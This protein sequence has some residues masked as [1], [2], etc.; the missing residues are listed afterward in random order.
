TLDPLASGVLVVCVGPATRLI[1]YIQRMP[2]SYRA[3]FRLGLASDTDDIEGNV[4][5]VPVERPP[6]RD[7]VLEQLKR[8]QGPIDQVPPNYSAVKLQGR[9]AY[10]L[11]RAQKSFV[12]QPRRVTIHR[13]TLLEYQFPDMRVDI[14]CSSGTYVRALGRDIAEGLGTRAV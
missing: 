2:K 5:A 6:S 14:E 4:E 8:F 13:L 3:A 7:E 1:E 11:A 9:R 10:E 12:L